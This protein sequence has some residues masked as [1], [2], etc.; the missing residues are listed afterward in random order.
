MRPRFSSWTLDNPWSFIRKRRIGRCFLLSRPTARPGDWSTGKNE[1]PEDGR[2]RTNDGR[3]GEKK[4]LSLC[5]H[6]DSSRGRSACGPR[7][8]RVYVE[9]WVRDSC[10]GQVQVV[11]SKITSL[12]NSSL[13]FCIDTS[14]SRSLIYDKYTKTEIKQKTLGIRSLALIQ[15]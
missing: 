9:D 11:G 15:S 14:E 7:A 6:P 1:V 2:P 5:L 4:D 12:L 10:P 3:G 8:L 13:E